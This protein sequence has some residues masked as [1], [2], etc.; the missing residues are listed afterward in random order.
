M[1]KIEMLRRCVGQDVSVIGVTFRG[2]LY[3]VTQGTGER[4]YGRDGGGQCAF[5]YAASDLCAADLRPEGWDYSEWCQE[6]SPVEG[7]GLAR[8]LA[9]VYGLRLTVGGSCAPVLSDE[10]FARLVGAS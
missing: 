4:S 9:R 1:T 8:K 6:I 10:Q 5:A 3:A 7:A 2:R